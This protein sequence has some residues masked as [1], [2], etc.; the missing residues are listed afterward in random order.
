M[1]Q[2]TKS[3]SKEFTKADYKRLDRL[4]KSQKKTQALKV[5]PEFIDSLTK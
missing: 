1:K 2:P 3:K 5:T 4:A